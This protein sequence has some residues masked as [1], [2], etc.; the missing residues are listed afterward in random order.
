MI[1]LQRPDSKVSAF[2]G[3]NKGIGNGDRIRPSLFT[4]A[5]H[6]GERAIVM[7]TLTGQCI[8]SS[9]FEWF[10]SPEERTFDE[11]DSEMKALVQRDFLVSPKIDEVKRYLNLIELLR[12]LD[13]PKKEGYELYTI[14][15]TTACNARCEQTLRYIHET[16]RPGAKVRFRWFGGEPLMGERIIDRIC[17]DMREKGVRYSSN[18]VSNGSLMTEEMAEKAKKEWHLTNI[19]ITLDGREDV[20]CERKRYV[21]FENSPYRSVLDGIHALLKR[22]VHVSIRLNVDEYNLDEISALID[23][24][25]DEFADEKR[26][27]LYTH[28]IFVE[29]E[30]ETGEF[31]EL[32]E[33]IDKLD[34]RLF[35]F[36]RK[37]RAPARKGGNKNGK[38][39]YYDR[40]VT[41]ARYY[42][43]ADNPSKGPVIV[44]SGELH[45][46]EHVGE[47]PV[48]GTVFDTKFVDK[49]PLVKKDRQTI[50]KCASCPLF[51]RCTD[52]TGCPAID[53]NCRRERMAKIVQR[54]EVY[55]SKMTPI[56]KLLWLWTKI[57]DIDN[58]AYFKTL[59]AQEIT[60]LRTRKGEY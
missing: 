58:N 38:K 56:G 16:R 47:L 19:Q 7:N 20:Y 24:L 55:I 28:G 46:C 51:P 57:P 10:E 14:L 2:L 30:E 13:N 17:A 35:Q 40:R 21:S 44:P 41:T 48:A 43:M 29:S 26:L 15:P 45:I 8:E 5:L 9:Y 18:M 39:K 60:F 42:C 11:N 59:I 4:V 33:G 12:K 53:K 52:F 34:E 37:R 3:S 32:Y 23:E 6:I 27:S 22:E 36:N 25:E 54:N 1:T 50:E 31:R 49:T